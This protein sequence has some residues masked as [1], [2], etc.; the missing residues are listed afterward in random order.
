MKK[1]FRI[2]GAVNYMVLLF[3]LDMAKLLRIFLRLLKRFRH[4]PVL[5][6]RCAKR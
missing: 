2:K 6:W 3:S 4:V 1:F 5:L